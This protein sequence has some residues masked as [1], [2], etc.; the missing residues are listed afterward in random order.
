MSSGI[1]SLMENHHVICYH[2]S[3]HVIYCELRIN[4]NLQ[5]PLITCR[6]ENIACCRV[7]QYFFRSWFLYI[8]DVVLSPLNIP[9]SVDLSRE[10]PNLTNRVRSSIVSATQSWES[11]IKTTSAIGGAE[12]RALQTVKGAEICHLKAAQ[13][14]T[15]NHDS[16]PFVREILARV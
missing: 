4:H 5:W 7:K 16:L 3:F 13:V 6:K 15:I 14:S 12:M 10:N 11:Y 2:H 9:H 8:H 1:H